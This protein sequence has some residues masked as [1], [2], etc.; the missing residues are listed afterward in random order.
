[1]ESEIKITPILP[2]VFQKKFSQRQKASTTKNTNANNFSQVLDLAIKKYKSD[3][4][5]LF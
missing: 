4:K 2:I 5:R 3:L 1:M